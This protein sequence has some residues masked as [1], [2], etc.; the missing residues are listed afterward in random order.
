MK[1][2]WSV[3]GIIFIVYM[4][5]LVALIKSMFLDTPSFLFRFSKALD[6]PSKPYHL[7]LERIYT[8]AQEDDFVA[9]V[10]GYMVGPRLDAY[11][12]TFLRFAGVVGYRWASNDIRKCQS[13]LG[14]L[15]VHL[16]LSMGLTGDAAFVPLLE[17]LLENALQDKPLSVPAPTVAGALYLINGRTDYR[18]KNESGQIQRLILN[19]TLT[20]ARKAITHSRG[21]KRTLEEMLILDRIYGLQE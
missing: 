11:G 13:K 2:I 9:E 7:L 20:E 1:K 6:Q 15:N 4:V 19:T 5:V 12:E 3:K 17:E 14:E 18:F 10:K 8:L 21:R 16:I